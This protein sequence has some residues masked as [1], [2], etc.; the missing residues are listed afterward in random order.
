MKRKDED[1]N[2]D[3]T[4]MIHFEDLIFDY[5]NTVNKLEKWLGLDSSSHIRKMELF[6]PSRS[7]NNTRVWK[8]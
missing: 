8:R 3:V 2:N 1:V 7:I 5:Y 4:I 6:D